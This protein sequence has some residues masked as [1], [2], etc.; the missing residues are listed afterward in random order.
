MIIFVPHLYFYRSSQKLCR[1]HDI[2]HNDTWSNDIFHND[3][4]KMGGTLHNKIVMF[5]VVI[6]IVILLSMV[7]LS[8]VMMTVVM[9]VRKVDLS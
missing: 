5:S 4:Q 7:M 6:L 8:V 1:C 9:I 2:Q 3:S